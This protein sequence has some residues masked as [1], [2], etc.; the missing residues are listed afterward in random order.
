MQKLEAADT[1]HLQEA[2]ALI[3]AGNVAAA[4]AELDAISPGFRDHPAVLVTR[5]SLGEAAMEWE[6]CL[7]LVEKVMSVLPENPMHW[8]QRSQYLR[9]MGRVQEAW[10]KLLPAAEKF[11]NFWM[12][13]YKLAGYACRL[14]N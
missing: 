3:G 1:K 9:E 4:R 2:Y 8:V 12:I 10:E 6:A 13:P 5:L 11:P 7:G 14:G